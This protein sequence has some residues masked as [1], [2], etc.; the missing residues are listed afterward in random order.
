MHLLVTHHPTDGLSTDARKSR[1]EYL[2]ATKS[3]ASPREEN[4]LAWNA[5][6]EE[7]DWRL[8]VKDKLPERERISLDREPT[9]RLALYPES[10]DKM[11][12]WYGKPDAEVDR[13][14]RKLRAFVD[15][16]YP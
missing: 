9:I 14:F 1:A 3:L 4:V 16:A 11:E 2:A 7:S 13:F 8:Q 12:D 6:F 5:A 15:L 10:L